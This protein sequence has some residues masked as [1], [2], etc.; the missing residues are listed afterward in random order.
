LDI[1]GEDR[2]SNAVSLGTG[3]GSVLELAE[4]EGEEDF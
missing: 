2:H 1:K 4:E 3:H